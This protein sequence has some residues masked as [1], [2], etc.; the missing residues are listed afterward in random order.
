MK[1]AVSTPKYLYKFFDNKEYMGQFLQGSI[2]FASLEVYKKIEDEKRKDIDEGRAR[3]KYRTDKMMYLKI[4]NETGKV[5]ER[6]YKPGDISITG[7]SPNKY[8]IFALSDERADLKALSEKF[9]KYVVK[10]KDIQKLLDLLNKNCKFSW[11]V[12]RIILE[13]VKYDKDNYIAMDGNS[14]HLPVGYHFAQKPERYSHECEWR[15]VVTGSA[16][17]EINEEYPRVEVGSI[18]D[19]AS[20]IDITTT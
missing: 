18:E 9:G 6:G 12:G 16:I 11:R 14:P 4:S 17:E 1:N 7:D 3:G 20:V 2:R 10:I 5:V 13:Q 8:F 15:L 19:I